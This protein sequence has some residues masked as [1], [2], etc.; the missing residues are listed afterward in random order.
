MELGLLSDVNS[1][2][3]ETGSGGV[4]VTVPA[5]FGA[6]LDIDTG[7]GSI[8]VELPVDNPRGDRDSLTGSV[9]DGN[10]RVKIETGSGGVRIRRG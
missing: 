1:L 6:Q 2:D 7:S 9:G 3:V 8:D 5:A 10:G 4:R